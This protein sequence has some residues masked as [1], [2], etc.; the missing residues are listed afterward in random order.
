MSELLFE[1]GCEEIPAAFVGPTLEQL[2]RLFKS[3]FAENRLFSSPE[4]PVFLEVLGTPRRLIIRASGLVETQQDERVEI[5]GPAESVAF[6]AERNATRAAQGFANKNGIDAKELVIKDGYVYANVVRNGRATVDI[7]SELLASIVGSL[8]FPKSM[9]WGT[10][11]FRFARPIRWIVALL[12]DKVIPVKVEHV[13]AG[14]VSRGHRFLA[15]DDFVLNSASE[16]LTKINDACVIVDQNRRRDMI[17]DQIK[18]LAES[19][20]GTVLIDPDLL[21][22]NVHLTE[23]PTAVL[24]EFEV[25]FLMLPRPVLVTAMRKHQRYFPIVDSTGNL[26][27]RFIAIR[28]GGSEYLD[29]VRSG[30][31]SVL[32]A[33]F[34]DAKFFYD[35]DLKSNLE[36]KRDLTKLIVFNEKLGSVRDKSDRLMRLADVVDVSPLPSLSLTV[37]RRAAFLCKA[38]L[39]TEMVKELPSLQGIVGQHYAT[40]DGETNEVALAISGHYQ[41]KGAGDEL[42]GGDT[43][44]VLALLDR[45]DTLVGYL[46]LGIVPTG[47]S[48]PFGL[49]RA[50]SGLVQLLNVVPVTISLRTLVAAAR[51]NYMDQGINFSQEEAD[52]Q[53][54]FQSLVNQR[55]DA[56]LEEYGIEHDIREAVLNVEFDSVNARV[57]LAKT[58]KYGKDSKDLFDCS[59]T[60]V[61]IG[62]ILRFAAKDDLLDRS[63]PVDSSLF[64]SQSEIELYD[65]IVRTRPAI[66]SAIA[67]GSWDNVLASMASFRGPVDRFFGEIMIMGDDS[68]LRNNRLRLLDSVYSMLIRIANFEKLVVADNIV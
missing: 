43:S 1:I 15:P 24:G 42:P 16:Y 34:A 54:S 10:R 17:T 29:I 68:D 6:D 67:T 50:A 36:S 20:H 25:E 5:K 19:V 52:V 32:R 9:R 8:T 33:R 58:I 38:D 31:E 22:E 47:T 3:K 45:L 28:N 46:S 23:Y 11:K 21:E 66:E 51:R 59:S 14:R 55:I 64:E 49:R 13:S 26:L 53:L 63:G 39:A 7:A 57:A 30:F 2:S 61:R 18:A 48:D 12:D 44:R 4:G 27:P 65:Y 60:A 41:P 40:R 35:L 56:L 62:N 37:L